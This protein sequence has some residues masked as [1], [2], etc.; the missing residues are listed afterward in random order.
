[1]KGQDPLLWLWERQLGFLE[2]PEV[3]AAPSEVRGGGRVEVNG[4]EP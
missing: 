3:Q 1:M 2:A 4:S